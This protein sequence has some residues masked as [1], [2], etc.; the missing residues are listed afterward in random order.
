MNVL[1]V[2]TYVPR[3]CGIAIFTKDLILGIK[4]VNPLHKAIVAAMV[5]PQTKHLRYPGETA[6]LI[7][8]DNLEE[9]DKVIREINSS[10]EIDLVNIQHE[11]GIFGGL[12]GEYI[13]SFA[14]ALKKPVITTLHTVSNPTPNRKK[15]LQKLGRYSDYIIVML[16]NAKTRLV[17]EYNIPAEK[18]AV[19]PYGVPDF[20]SFSTKNSKEKL[21]LNNKVVMAS[22]NLISEW[23]GLEYAVASLPEIISKIPNFIYLVIGETHPNFI[24]RQGGYDYYRDS[25]IKLAA[26][27]KVGNHIKFINRYLSLAELADYMSA[28]DFF[29]TPYL[30]KE[31]SSSG[32]LSYAVGAGKVC[33]STPYIYAK[34]ILSK[35]RGII[36][37]F[38]N[39]QAITIAK[40]ITCAYFNPQKRSEIKKNAYKLGKTMTLDNVGKK[41]LR[42]YNKLL[43]HIDQPVLEP[44]QPSLNYL[45][46]ENLV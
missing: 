4:S 6:F 40:A 25:L 36:V 26:R 42:L 14:K 46:K 1:Y 15:I 8:Q 30:Y 41:Y 29:I 2:S 21:G 33:I 12:D 5:T 44:E 45:Y 35:N 24:K 39:S 23:K 28:S 31:Q 32:S 17:S 16:D 20:T 43:N 3:K 10:K 19:I 38:K 11:Y 7:N 34:Q 13:A 22:V 18:I 9:Y 27:L 37:P